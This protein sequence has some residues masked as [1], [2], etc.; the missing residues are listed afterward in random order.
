M[1]T[2]TAADIIIATTQY[3]T[4][5]LKQT[6]KNPLIPPSDTITRKSLFQ[7]DYIFSNASSALKSQQSPVFKLPRVSTPKLFLHSQGCIHLLYNIFTIYPLQ[8]K[9]NCRDIQAEYPQILQKCHRFFLR[10]QI[11]VQMSP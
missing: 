3:S 5:A 6:S 11:Q 10:H 1:S 8:H 7:I 9:N 2:A 4:S